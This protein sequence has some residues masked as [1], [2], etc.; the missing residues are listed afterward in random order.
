MNKSNTIQIWTAF[1]PSGCRHGHGQWLWIM[2]PCELQ[3]AAQEHRNFGSASTGRSRRFSRPSRMERS[4]Q[5][6]TCAKIQLL[7]RW[8]QSISQRSFG[9]AR[10]SWFCLL[11][12]QRKSRT[13]QSGLNDTWLRRSIFNAWGCPVIPSLQ[14]SSNIPTSG[15]SWIK[16]PWSL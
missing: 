6:A 7:S 1:Y 12:Q 15:V 8:S 14:G 11:Q 13:G 4:Q 9:M 3:P 16:L 2:C 10:C 5:C